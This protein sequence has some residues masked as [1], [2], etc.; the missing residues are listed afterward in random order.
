MMYRYFGLCSFVGLRTKEGPKNSLD[1]QTK[2][3]KT[4]TIKKQQTRQYYGRVSFA[5][6][7]RGPLASLPFF[8]L[9]F[10]ALLSSKNKIHHHGG[11]L[12]IKP[13]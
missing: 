11:Q 3:Q 2:N 9:S 12:V 7:N 1:E 6:E 10:F 4:V 13:P 8:L 5:L